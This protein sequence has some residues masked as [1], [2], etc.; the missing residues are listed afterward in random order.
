LE[1]RELLVLVGVEACARDHR[2]RAVLT[3]EC[4]GGTVDLAA[5]SHSDERLRT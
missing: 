1:V 4:V 5:T 2:F 3:D